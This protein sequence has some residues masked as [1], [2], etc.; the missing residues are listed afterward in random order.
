MVTSR[1]HIGSRFVRKT[2]MGQDEDGCM[3]GIDRKDRLD[4]LGGSDLMVNLDRTE[5]VD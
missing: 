2:G 5:Q 3:A 1:E 4:W